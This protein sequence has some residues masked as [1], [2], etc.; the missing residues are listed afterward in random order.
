V[1]RMRSFGNS[2]WRHA[3]RRPVLPLTEPE[4]RLRRYAITCRGHG[5]ATAATD[6]RPPHPA[7]C[8]R[9]RRERDQRTAMTSRLTCRPGSDGSWCRQTNGQLRSKLFLAGSGKGPELDVL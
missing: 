6:P 9:H 1:I 5:M 2:C 3:A 8:E 4:I 7:G